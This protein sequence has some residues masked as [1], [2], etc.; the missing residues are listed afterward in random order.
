MR[1]L[2]FPIKLLIGLIAMVVGFLP[3]VLGAI[4]IAPLIH[5]STRQ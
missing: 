5:S 3:A 4:A 2:L 1:K